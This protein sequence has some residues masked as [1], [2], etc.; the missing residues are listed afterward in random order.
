MYDFPGELCDTL[1]M[2]QHVLSPE[3]ARAFVPHPLMMETHEPNC[4]PLAALMTAFTPA[5]CAYDVQR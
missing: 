1:G 4:D 5:L 2:L 3:A